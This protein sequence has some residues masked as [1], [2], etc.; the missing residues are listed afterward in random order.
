[1]D[2]TSKASPMYGGGNVGLGNS[3]E[4]CYFLVAEHG[5]VTRWSIAQ[6]FARFMEFSEAA[7]KRILADYELQLNFT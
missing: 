5:R 4:N 2:T 6:T 1:M 3:I 7:R